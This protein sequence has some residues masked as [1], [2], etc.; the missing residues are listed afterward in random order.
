VAE[1]NVLAVELHQNT[2]DLPDAS[3]D[4]ALIGNL[5]LGPP[6]ISITSPT[7]GSILNPAVLGIT[8]AVSDLD[9]SIYLVDFYTNGAFLGRSMAPPFDLLW[10]ASQAGRYALTARAVDNS[11]RSASSMPVHVQIGAV[12]TDRIARGPY[13]QSGSS[14]GLVVRWRTDWFT[15]SIVRYGTHPLLLD[16]VAGSVEPTVEHEVQLGGLISD[17][18][19]FYSIGTA[20]D[21]LAG[22]LD[23]FF[24]TAPT[25]SKPVRIWVIGDSGTAN[26]NAAPSVTPM[27][28]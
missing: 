5:P 17:E 11:G 4:L 7:N 25:Q 3:F 10:N 22:G 26:T 9:G 19:Y 15:G 27:W 13:L 2:N 23:Y 18:K 20:D 6:A 24:V 16:S 8:T 12:T 14:T 28:L 21:T 1:T